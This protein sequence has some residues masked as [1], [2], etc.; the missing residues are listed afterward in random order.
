[1]GI[2]YTATEPLLWLMRVKRRPRSSLDKTL[3]GRRCKLRI[4]D[5]DGA[6]EK[7]PEKITSEWLAVEKK[8]S[9]RFGL[10]Y[11]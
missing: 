5:L 11:Q 4:N 2:G 9:Q 8:G 1:M 6:L 3:D 7:P 10:L